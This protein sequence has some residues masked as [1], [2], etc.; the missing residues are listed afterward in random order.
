M[1]HALSAG[2]L[3]LAFNGLSQSF[4]GGTGSILDNQTIDIPISVSGLPAAIDTTNFGLEQVCLDIT[5]TY[6]SDMDISLVAPDGTVVLMISA[7][8]GSGDDFSA[9][10]L[11]EDA[12]QPISSASAPFTG[13][14]QP[15]GQIGMVNNG[16]NPNGT[17]FLR[18]TDNYAGDEGTVNSC[19]ITFGNNPATYFVFRSSNLPIVVINTNGQAIQDDPKIMA[20]FD[21]IYNGP[22]QRN[23][24]TDNTFD[25]HGKAGIEIRGEYS[26]SLPQKP[27]GVELWDVNGNT[28]D[29]PVLGM[30]AQ[31]DW[32]L[33][34]NY[35][36]KSFVRNVVPFSLFEE[37]GNYATRTRYVDLVLNGDYQGIYLLGEK[38]K[39]DS[40]RVDISKLET[41]DIYGQ[42][43]TGGYIVKF[44]YWD[45]S[46]S[47]QLNHSPIGYPGLDIHMVYDYPKPE[48]IVPQQKTYI[49][50]FI[51][52]FENALYGSQFADPTTGY[53]Q[54]IS[55][56][57]FID[58]FIVSEFT[59]NV[60][61]Y[62]KSHYFHKD[63]D[64]S[65]GDYRKLKAG[66][67][68]DFDWAMKDIDGG[69]DG[70]GWMYQS[71]DEDVNAAGWEIRLLEDTVF[72]NELR[73]RYEDIRRNILSEAHIFARID[74]VAS[75]LGESQGWHFQRWGNLGVAT[76]T[77]EV[78]A[79]SQTYAEEIQKLKDWIHRRLVWMDA[80]MFGTLN[81]CSFMG[82]ADLQTAATLVAWP[83]PFKSHLTIEWPEGDFSGATVHFL[84]QS[85][86][87][88]NS[89]KAAEIINTEGNMEL[90]TAENLSNGVYFVEIVQG[91][92]RRTLKVIK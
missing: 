35:N 89:W 37:M 66:P 55:T 5:H 36:D 1:K 63:K 7:L 12:S 30:P 21:I 90:E 48:D 69:T 26:S 70:S 4:S 3:L 40:N 59:R 20:D 51:D 45:A 67:V 84:D 61:G 41:T 9:T 11:R 52:G 19:S 82:L 14:F 71:C 50:A 91:D 85:G 49:Q 57:T 47:W 81:G 74:S 80:N 44:D 58:Y 16:Q 39:R 22:G 83:N 2:V 87:E 42:D 73:C 68:W 65:N 88:I 15:Q 92:S 60:D 13:T 34:A 29:A 6:D 23:H 31:N 46:D 77:P 86:R 38:I 54:F 32:V 43:V 76:G 56:S 78:E 25:Y 72:A 79:P 17:W 33:L 18:V 28:I 8:G 64:H 75:Y 27:Y 53:R 24:I 62:K 10:C